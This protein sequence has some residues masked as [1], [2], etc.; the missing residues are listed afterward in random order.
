MTTAT[1]PTFAGQ[2][3]VSFNVTAAVQA[4]ASGALV[5][6]GFA[7]VITGGD[8][9][10]HDFASSEY[11]DAALRPRL[12]V[13][14]LVGALP[15]PVTEAA[16]APT[17]TPGPAPAPTPSPTPTTSHRPRKRKQARRKPPARPTVRAVRRPATARK[18]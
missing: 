11:A 5:N 8:G 10:E 13:R 2:D 3:W 15:V 17:P 9:T 14:Y 4:W 6:N 18:G 1:I 12:M 16:P 7:F